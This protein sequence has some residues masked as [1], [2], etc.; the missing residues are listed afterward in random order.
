MYD[1][2]VLDRLRWLASDLAP[3]LSAALRRR[4]GLALKG[5]VARGL[6]MGDE[7]HQRNVACTSLFLREMA[8]ALAREAGGAALAEVLAFIGGNDQ[9]FLNVAMAMADSVVD[10]R[11][12]SPVT[13]LERIGSFSETVLF[14]AVGV[15]GMLAQLTREAPE[16]GTRI[17]VVGVCMQQDTIQ[18]MAAIEK[19]LSYKFVLG[20]TPDEF[21][22]SLQALESGLI[23]AGPVVTGAVDLDNVAGAF[24]TLADP[25]DHCKIMVTPHEQNAL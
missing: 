16:R 3:V 18:P 13:A 15:P 19:E 7:M 21:E 14:D 17:V 9:F 8:P 22:E 20:Y 23:D 1:A 6:S 12:L 24:E 4:G 11:E 10:P 25:E 2:G 5:I